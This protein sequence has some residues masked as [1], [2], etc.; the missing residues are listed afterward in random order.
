[1]RGSGGVSNAVFLD[2]DAGYMVV[3]SWWKLIELDTYMHF[4]VCIFQYKVNTCVAY[5][6][7]KSQIEERKQGRKTGKRGVR[8]GEEC[9]N[10][11]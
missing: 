9:S 5:Q 10:L 11:K 4:T 8:G 6:M 7:V 2:L 3:F 1:M